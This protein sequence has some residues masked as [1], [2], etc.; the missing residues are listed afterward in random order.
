MSIVARSEPFW[1]LL[2]LDLF[3]IPKQDRLS[4]E[5]LVHSSPSSLLNGI[6]HF[7]RDL[8]WTVLLDYHQSCGET[9][10]RIRHET[11]LRQTLRISVV[12]DMQRNV[13]Q[14][15]ICAPAST[16]TCHLLSS[17]S[18]SL[19]NRTSRRMQAYLRICSIWWRQTATAGMEFPPDEKGTEIRTSTDWSLV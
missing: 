4:P 18:T 6:Y 11:F 2:S 1:V 5:R 17:W 9:C 19:S 14:L 13:M 3:I 12:H 7:R 15:I 10:A 16:Y 8:H